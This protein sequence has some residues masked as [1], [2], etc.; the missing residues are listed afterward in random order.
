[1]RFLF[2]LLLAS[3]ISA[4]KTYQKNYFD[5]GVLKEEGWIKD[6]QKIDFWTFYYSDGKIKEMANS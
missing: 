5:N 4:Q 2:L 1:M 3:T 6:N